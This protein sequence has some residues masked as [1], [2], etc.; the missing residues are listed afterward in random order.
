[1]RTGSSAAQGIKLIVKQSSF[2]VPDHKPTH[3]FFA[4]NLALESLRFDP[5]V[6]RSLYPV[7]IGSAH[8]SAPTAAQQQ[9]F[10]TSLNGYLETSL[11]EVHL[12]E[13]QDCVCTCQPQMGEKVVIRL[14]RWLA[15]ALEEAGKTFSNNYPLIQ[16]FM[17]VAFLHETAH[18]YGL[19]LRQDEHSPL[20]FTR[21]GREVVVPQRDENG[22]LVMVP[23][24]D[25]LEGEIGEAG[26]MLEVQLFG[27]GMKLGVVAVVKREQSPFRTIQALELKDVHGTHYGLCECCAVVL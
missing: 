1:M 11:P 13:T 24:G 27:G 3:T 8:T 17:I 23:D 22:Q 20:D 18:A 19:Y 5:H 10:D 4:L 7:Y 6:R 15:V 26:Y 25:A 12:V 14:D 16:M 2:I 9:Q 21:A